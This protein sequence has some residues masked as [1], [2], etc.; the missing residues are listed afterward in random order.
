M[1][2]F[3]H[4]S[5]LELH[6]PFQTQVFLQTTEKFLSRFKIM[7]SPPCV[8]FFL[9]GFVLFPYDVSWVFLRQG[10]GFSLHAFW[11]YF[12]FAFC[13]LSSIRFPRSP[14][15]PPIH[16]KFKIMFLTSG[17][18]FLPHLIFFFNACVV[19]FLPVAVQ[20]WLDPP[21]V[22]SELQA[23]TPSCWFPLRAYCFPF[24]SPQPR[25]SIYILLSSTSS[26][27]LLRYN[28][29]IKTTYS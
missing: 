4:H 13:I 9:L 20:L 19:F 24:V 18:Y 3:F 10:L 16:L 14:S 6:E 27:A 25:T 29:Q 12:C 7:A 8:A 21:V 26:P 11:C 2:D 15:S 5:C 23:L 22:L 17:K 1:S 28:R